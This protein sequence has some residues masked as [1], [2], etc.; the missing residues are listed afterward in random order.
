MKAQIVRASANPP[1]PSC[2]RKQ[3]SIGFDGRD[4]LA[5]R[6][7]VGITTPAHSRG[8]AITRPISSMEPDVSQA[9]WPPRAV[10]MPSLALA[11]M[12]VLALT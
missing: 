12:S 2:L 4:A 7:L 6:T 1:N 8:C 9:G 5:V 11:L 3:A 10:L